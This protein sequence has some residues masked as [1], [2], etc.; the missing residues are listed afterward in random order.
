[1]E[2]C[3]K[4]IPLTRSISEVGGAVMKQAIGDIFRR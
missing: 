1:V 3:P 4:D 2:V